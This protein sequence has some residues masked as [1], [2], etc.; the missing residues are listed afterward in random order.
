MRKYDQYVLKGCWEGEQENVT[1]TRKY[2]GLKKKI[3]FNRLYDLSNLM[4]IYT[5]TISYIKV[6]YNTVWELICIFD[7]ES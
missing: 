3:F 5:D 1:V 6:A 7:N 2:K 4:A